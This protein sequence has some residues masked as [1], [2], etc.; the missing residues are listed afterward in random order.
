MKLNRLFGALLI[1]VV[2]VAVGVVIVFTQLNQQQNSFSPSKAVLEPPAPGYIDNSGIYLLSAK[3]YYGNYHGTPLFI[4]NVTVRN[5]YTAENPPP[6]AIAGNVG[7][8]GS[9]VFLLLY[10]NL[11]NENGHINSQIYVP[12]GDN[13]GY[14]PFDYYVAELG[15]GENASLS[16]YM[17]TSQRDV[18]KYTLTFGWL[19]AVPK[20]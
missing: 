5:D 17:V 2:V 6:N 15:S 20:L 13:S 19:D 11:Y 14:T 7:F 4:V 10:A 12:G 9:T 8:N 1:I 16:I 18:E 3:P